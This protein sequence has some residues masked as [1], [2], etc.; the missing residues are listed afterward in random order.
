MSSQP[1]APGIHHPMQMPESNGSCSF[2]S[3]PLMHNP[4][5]PGNNLQ[6][7]DASLYG[8]T[9]NLRPPYPSP[10]NQFSYFQ[11]DQQIRPQ[12]EAPA[13]SYYD[14]PH[15]GQNVEGGHF[16]GDQGSIRPPRHEVTDGWGYSRPPFPAPVHSENDKTYPP[17]YSAP[18]CEP[19][20]PH[21]QHGWA[22]PPHPVHHRNHMP[23]RPPCDGPVPVP[24]RAPGYWRPI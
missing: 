16:Y 7:A 9:G 20:R 11:A 8:K 10:S 13:P 18:T 23:S 15:F 4:V 24:V 14:R 19:T 6:Q 12:R 21:N 5:P 1:P 3:Y 22:Y 17:M 2:N